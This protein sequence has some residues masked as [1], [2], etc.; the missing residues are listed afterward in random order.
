MKAAFTLAIVS[1]ILLWGCS[2]TKNSPA[3][4]LES[5]I[6]QKVLPYK[7]DEF[8]FFVPGEYE[9][10]LFAVYRLSGGDTLYLSEIKNNDF[11]PVNKAVLSDTVLFSNQYDK[12][13]KDLLLLRRCFMVN[14][15]TLIFFNKG[16][17]SG[18]V[19]SRRLW[20]FVFSENIS[21][22]IDSFEAPDYSKTNHQDVADSCHPTQVMAWI[23]EEKALVS[24]FFY[25]YGMSS[26][27]PFLVKFFPFSEQKRIVLDVTLPAFFDF[28]QGTVF[29]GSIFN[30]VAG[31]EQGKLYVAFGISSDMFEISNNEVKVYDVKHPNFSK[32][33][34][35]QITDLMKGVN[36][37]DYVNVAKMSFMY[38]NLVYDKYENVLYR[39]YEMEMPDRNEDGLKNVYPD[40]KKL[41]LNV[42]SDDFSS[43]H[44][45]LLERK[46]ACFYNPFTQKFV[47]EDGVYDVFFDSESDSLKIVKLSIETEK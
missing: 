12:V 34:S 46:A 29:P 23:P 3:S 9:G 36:G 45:V 7:S 26:K 38:S 4:D 40:D 17:H 32:P 19:S 15:D 20:Y 1:I 30:Y 14:L 21:C 35:Y 42:I 10:K 43:V 41:G 13:Y 6:T 18:E 22:V 2:K 28:P 37:D 31:G 47:L 8:S 33:K 11:N 27:A 44:E 5:T 25:Y 24:Y 39:F 16:T